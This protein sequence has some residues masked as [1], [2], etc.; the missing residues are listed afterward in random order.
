MIGLISRLKLTFALSN[1]APL[2]THTSKERI[3]EP[4]YPYR[5]ASELERRL[6]VVDATAIIVGIVIGAGIFVSPQIAA[7]SVPN[8]AA[9][10]L[11]WAAA[12]LLA[13]CGS[14]AYGEL[15]AMMPQTGGQYVFL[16]EAYSP[17]A[18]FLCGWGIFWIIQPA[19]LAFLAASL[20]RYVPA[21]PQLS[22]YGS[23]VLLAVLNI[24]G[25]G[26]AALFQRF[27][28]IVKTIGLL[29]LFAAA[30]FVER[31]ATIDWSLPAAFPWAAAGVALI[32][33][34]Y[35]YEGWSFASFIVGEL[36]DPG[37]DLPRAFALSLS[38]CAALY[39]AANVAYLRVLGAEGVVRSDRAASVVAE[40]GLGA[41][42]EI[43]LT[44]TAIFCIVSSL[45]GVLMTGARVT[46][47]QARDRLFFA[48][49]GELHPRF[50]T[51]A[52]SIAGQ[53]ALALL[54][55]ATGFYERL[56]EYLMFTFAVLNLPTVLAVAVLRRR[57]PE[58]ERAY[59]MWGYPWTLIV[60]AVAV[61]W[62]IAN[63]LRERPQPAWT[64]IA[65]LAAGVP[66]YWW[67]KRR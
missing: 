58:R 15:A 29:L 61:T 37:R 4:V 30:F 42:G 18:G 7:Q 52:A 47:A 14:L 6:D 63:T 43:A 51:P 34:L 66:V 65:V 54:V 45:N 59:R 17:L 36:R 11:I 3:A 8:P 46:Y 53:S 10:L 49:F 35:T 64:A 28:T 19:V 2:N 38:L 40:R 1:A 22:A 31:P 62:F 16:R 23:L 20:G 56:L 25:V 48:P 27:S 33:V 67:W 60:F 32:A 24:V 21:A 44:F 13:F 5:M 26:P 39:M 50:G 9:M 55:L 12:G 57:A 41:V